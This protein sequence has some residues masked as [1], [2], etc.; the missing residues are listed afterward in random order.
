M[1]SCNDVSV[2]QYNQSRHPYNRIWAPMPAI[3]PIGILNG[4][5]GLSVRV[6]NNRVSGCGM[7]L[8]KTP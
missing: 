5:N 6:T 2:D 4:T 1:F 3:V 8:E 7:R